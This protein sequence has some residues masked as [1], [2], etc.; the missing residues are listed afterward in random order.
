MPIVNGCNLPDELLYDVPNQ[1]WYRERPDGLV[2]AGITSVA[3]AMAGTIV[4]VTPRRAG[5]RVLA[6]NACA[7]FESGKFVGPARVAFAGEIVRSNEALL[8]R[9]SLAQADPYGAGWLVMLKP[10]DWPAA[11]A[12]LTPGVAVAGPYG[13]KMRLE[14]FAGCQPP[15]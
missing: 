2:E 8:D 13:E 6:G 10:D 11:K 3:A 12:L 15:S 7:V 4:A 14:K 5:R 1:V 9:P